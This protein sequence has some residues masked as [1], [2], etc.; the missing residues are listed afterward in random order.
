MGETTG[1]FF[2]YAVEFS[3]DYHVR[4]PRYQPFSVY[5]DYPGALQ[6]DTRHFEHHLPPCLLACYLCRGSVT[7]M[8]SKKNKIPILA[9]YDQP[10]RL[11]SFCFIFNSRSICVYAVG[12]KIDKRTTP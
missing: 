9:T 11:S 10:V 12:S 7:C 5:E 4:N 3:L 2:S 1:A 6:D 8:V